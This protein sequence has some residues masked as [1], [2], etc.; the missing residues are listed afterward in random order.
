MKRSEKI[1]IMQKIWGCEKTHSFCMMYAF[2]IKMSLKSFNFSKKGKKIKWFE[3][4]AR[5]LERPA[6]SF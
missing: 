6:K 2:Y 3:K 5:V 4:M 1:E